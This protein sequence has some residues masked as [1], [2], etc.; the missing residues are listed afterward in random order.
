VKTV[1]SALATHLASEN[2]TLARLLK[3]TRTKTDGAVIRITDH[4]ANISFSE[5][6][7]SAVNAETNVGTGTAQQTSPIIPVS[8]TDFAV[9]VTSVST[10]P[11]PVGWSNPSSCV[12][13]KQLSSGLPF[14]VTDLLG[15][16]F[17]GTP[18]DEWANVIATFPTI[19]PVSQLQTKA[20]SPVGS[21]SGPTT[22]TMSFDASVTQGSTL[23]VAVACTTP[24]TLQELS[25]IDS[26]G[27]AYTTKY[28][29]TTNSNYTVAA[30]LFIAENVPAG[31]LTI[32]VTTPSNNYFLELRAF[33]MAGISS[34]IGDYVASDGL[35]VSAIEHKAD[36]SPNNSTVTGFLAP[37]TPTGISEADVRA[38]LYDGATF[39][40]RVVN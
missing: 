40:L 38:H 6:E 27:N 23:L 2:T 39:E 34:G 24:G 10:L 21:V 31:S 37:Y 3:I 29:Q 7:T 13:T 5:T 20:F 9:I 26:A 22:S 1:T 15:G 36:R 11:G 33:E 19:G 8:P 28:T 12:Y 17:Q 14:S 4:D 25:I 18:E 30:Y 32:S 16:Q 35:T